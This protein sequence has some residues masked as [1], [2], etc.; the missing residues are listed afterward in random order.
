MFY[1]KFWVRS[2]LLTNMLLEMAD[3]VYIVFKYMDMIV[4][5]YGHDGEIVKKY[6]KYLVI[7]IL[8]IDEH[9]YFFITYFIYYVFVSVYYGNEATNGK[10]DVSEEVADLLTKSMNSLEESTLV[11]SS[12]EYEVVNVK[13]TLPP[14]PSIPRLVYNITWFYGYYYT[15]RFFF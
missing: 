7:S 10:R 3:I 5:L 6:W 14:R 2:G 11:R 13:P 4:K 15:M 1:L 12:D 9:K 8:I